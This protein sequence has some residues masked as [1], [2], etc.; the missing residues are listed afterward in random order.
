MEREKERGRGPQHVGQQSS[1]PPTRLWWPMYRDN[2]TWSALWWHAPQPDPGRLGLGEEAG[3]PFPP[4]SSLDQ[5]GPATIPRSVLPRRKASL[6]I[7]TVKPTMAQWLKNLTRSS[8][9]GSVVSEPD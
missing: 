9:R 1:A 2:V 6:I 3:A 5:G 7:V 8:H 4:W